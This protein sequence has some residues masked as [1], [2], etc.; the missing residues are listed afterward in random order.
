[1]VVAIDLS[2]VGHERNGA[3]GTRT[4]RTRAEATIRVVPAND[5][6]WSDLQKI[7]GVR[8]F[9]SRC[10]CQRYKIRDFC[11]SDVPEGERAERMHEQT[12]CDDPDAPTTSG[13]VAY[14]DGEPAGWCAVEP[15]TEYE[16]LLVNRIPWAGR[17]EDKADPDIWAVVCFFVRA[18]FRKRG[19]GRALARATV[20]F[21]RERGA[22]AVEGYPMVTKDVLVGELHVGTPDMF[23]AAGY[24]EVN[25]P[26]ARRAVMRID[27]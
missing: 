23:A 11:E 8:G 10:W 21:A 16:R 12:G 1:M 6:S 26:A 22:K 7:F 17:H 14:V 27:F 24:R 19:V 4:A 25:R 20:D 18:G 2:R 5:A 3:M 13:L 15:R 9:A